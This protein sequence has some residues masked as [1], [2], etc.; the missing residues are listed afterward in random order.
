MPRY[1]FD[2]HDGTELTV[3]EIGLPCAT[4]QDVRD[5]AIKA[6]PE[7]AKDE[8]PDGPEHCFWVKVRDENGDYIFHASLM[9]KSGWLKANR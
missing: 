8:L 4:E 5:E 1:F 9:L 6:L 2:I 7:I 3:D